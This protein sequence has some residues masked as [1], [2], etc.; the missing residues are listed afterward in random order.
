MV[1]RSD[2]SGFPPERPKKPT[3]P[4][5]GVSTGGNIVLFSEARRG[6]VVGQSC[7]ASPGMIK[8][9]PIGLYSAAWD[10]ANFVPYAGKVTLYNE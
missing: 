9:N 6:T 10:E 5:I 2:A 4:W 8:D 3:Y 7:I 1:A